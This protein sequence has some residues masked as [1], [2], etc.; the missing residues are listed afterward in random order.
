[1]KRLGGMLALIPLALAPWARAADKPL[2]P[3]KEENLTYAIR[4]PGGVSLGDAHLRARAT[5]GG[6]EFD[7]WLDAGVPGYSLSDRYRAASSPRLCSLELQK[8]TTHGRRETHEKTTFDYTEATATRETTGGGKTETPIPA[9]ARDGLTFLF[10]A[11]SELAQG[12]VPPPQTVM[13]GAS[14]QVQIESAGVQAIQVGGKTEEADRE[15]I[16]VKGPASDLSFEA[17]FAR[18]KV[19]TPLVVSCPFSMGILSLEL[20]R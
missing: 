19:R 3:F 13:E 4:G 7:F 16:S 20:V 11:R 8:D 2:F 5:P 9:C 12:R 15:V 14:Y 18:D 10:F 6:W 17:Y 1:M